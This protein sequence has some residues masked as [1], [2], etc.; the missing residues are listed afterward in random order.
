M[1]LQPLSR[2][3]RIASSAI[4]LILSL[5]ACFANVISSF[6]D[7]SEEWDTLLTEEW[8]PGSLG[9]SSTSLPMKDLEC[10]GY[11]NRI[12]SLPGISWIEVKQLMRQRP[13][14]LN[15]DQDLLRIV[16]V[17]Q[18]DEADNCVL[19]I[20]S[21]SALLLPLQMPKYRNMARL[22]SNDQNFLILNVSFYDSLRSGF[23][24][25]GIIDDLATDDYRA[26][27]ESEESRS[28]FE[29]L[30]EAS[31]CRSP[32]VQRL[33]LELQSWRDSRSRGP[34]TNLLLA[35]TDVFRDGKAASGLGDGGCRPAAAAALLAMGLAR[36]QAACDVS[37]SKGSLEAEV[38][39][40]VLRDSI[41]LTTRAEELIRSYSWS[42]GVRFGQLVATPWN[43]WRL[44]NHM[45]KALQ[46]FLKNPWKLPGDA[47]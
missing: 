40:A 39:A 2:F 13:K 4:L 14:S 37:S 22:L 42:E 29:P 26:W 27:F 45:Q 36:L 31:A 44:L 5:R 34:S 9:N 10:E 17:L 25:F 11:H 18:R 30:Q 23:P 46:C 20:T 19:G 7:T 16:V 21:T 47:E 15:D 28:F 35:A 43:F 32:S 24:I 8:Q 41:E 1:A 33:L 12:Q 3:S 6:A 38:R